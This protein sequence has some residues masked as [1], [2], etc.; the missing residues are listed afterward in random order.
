MPAGLAAAVVETAA[1]PG[2]PPTP[3]GGPAMG[4]AEASSA[5]LGERVQEGVGEAGGMGEE[6][7]QQLQ[8]KAALTVLLR[9]GGGG[10]SRGGGG[11]SDGTA[12]GSEEGWSPGVPPQKFPALRAA[13]GATATAS[14]GAGGAAMATGGGAAAGAPAPADAAAA[15]TGGGGGGADFAGPWS[16]KYSNNDKDN[17]NNGGGGGPTSGANS[18]K[19]DNNHNNDT[20][21]AAAPSP[22]PSPPPPSL[23]ISSAPSQV[24]AQATTA[25]TSSAA[26]VVTAAAAEKTSISA[27]PS[28]SRTAASGNK[29]AFPMGGVVSLADNGD[30]GGGDGGG[31]GDREGV[32]L[33]LE[34]PDGA[35]KGAGENSG[36]D[37]INSLADSEKRFL[38]G[39]A[40]VDATVAVS[41]AI[42]NTAAAAGGGAGDDVVESAVDAQD[43]GPGEV[44]EVDAAGGVE[45]AG[46]TVRRLAD[47][48]RSGGD[49]SSDAETNASRCV[50]V[51]CFLCVS[52]GAFLLFCRCCLSHANLLPSSQ[53]FQYQVITV[54]VFNLDSAVCVSCCC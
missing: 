31:K 17:S 18:N 54:Q 6:E 22:P 2:V 16:G 53:L 24:Q 15:A 42:A 46:K 13:T 14:A 30:H 26:T 23:T 20:A 33:T 7:Q 38:S 21:A 32:V 47:W 51:W 43:K 4:V 1:S 11:G 40:P 45:G 12:A 37:A 9:G 39:A 50:S 48:V 52:L 8:R 44:G 3:P 25:V 34:V 36:A 35:T 5:G 10:G 49:D 19:T 27:R 29:Q 28:T 41:M